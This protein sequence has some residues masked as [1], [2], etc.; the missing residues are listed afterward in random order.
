MDHGILSLH[1]PFAKPMGKSLF[2]VECQL[3]FG[4]LVQCSLVDK[5]ESNRTWWIFQDG[6]SWSESYCGIQCGIQ[7]HIVYI[8]AYVSWWQNLFFCLWIKD[9]LD[10]QAV[11]RSCGQQ[12]L[13]MLR[14]CS[15]RF[16]QML[17]NAQPKVK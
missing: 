12:E 15:A 13:Q 7:R 10:F 14:K 5:K 9:R 3:I 6:I 11:Q 4:I 1:C 8:L 16:S 17:S 2:Q